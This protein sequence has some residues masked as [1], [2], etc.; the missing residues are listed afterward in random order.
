M[1]PTVAEVRAVEGPVQALAHAVNAVASDLVSDLGPSA[2]F[3]G[4]PPALAPRPANII[5]TGEDDTSVEAE[6]AAAPTYGDGPPEVGHLL[7]AQLLQCPSLAEVT[8]D[9]KQ[10]QTSSCAHGCM[11]HSCIWVLASC[12]TLFAL[13]AH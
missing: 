1:T 11:F 8:V 10:A 6:A 7:H 12:K 13:G 2:S 4:M 9:T 3:T 5:V